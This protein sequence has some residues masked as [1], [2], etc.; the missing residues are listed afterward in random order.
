MTPNDALNPTDAAESP[1]AASP[2]A[3][4]RSGASDSSQLR[5][6]LEALTS[7]GG[8]FITIFLL[9]WLSANAEVPLLIAPFGASCVLVF[10]LPNSPL[11][12]PRNVVGGHLIAAAAGLLALLAL[13]ATPLGY[14]LGVA[15]AIL[16]MVLTKT[17]HP[18]AGAN[19]IVV[20]L[21]GASWT[22]LAVPVLAG[23]VLIVLIGLIYHRFL[24]RRTYPV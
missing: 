3:M 5:P 2:S 14:A 11:A 24:S 18:P 16:G 10:A 9:A 22:F 17:V 19:P 23:T 1:T 20:L 21:A 12:Q 7:A 13:G 8:G 15:M 4:A 6:L